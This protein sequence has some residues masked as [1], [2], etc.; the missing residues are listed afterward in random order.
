MLSGPKTERD[1][2]KTIFGILWP[3][4]P[5]NLGLHLLQFFY[6]ETPW[7][8]LRHISSFSWSLDRREKEARHAT[9]VSQSLSNCLLSVGRNGDSG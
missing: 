5:H 2:T 1:V 8:G 9:A 6:L 7:A 3:R 4:L